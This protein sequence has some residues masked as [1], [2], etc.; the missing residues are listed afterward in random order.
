MYCKKCGKKIPDDANICAYCG[1]SV[2][3]MPKTVL[4]K[5]KKKR[6]CLFWFAIFFAVV[7]GFGVIA[8]I[9]GHNK[10][11]SANNNPPVPQEQRAYKIGETFKSDAFEITI[12]GKDSVK[13]VNDEGG[14]LYSDANGIFVIVHLQYKNIADSAKSLDS[15][16]FKLISNGKEYSPTI[17]MIRMN[18]NIFH[19]TINPGIVKNGEIYFDVPEEIAKSNLT[20]K[21][22]SSFVSDNFSGEVNLF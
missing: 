4:Q 19:S 17:L 16:A 5:T 22:S 14:Y 21:M 7:I 13:R 3:D 11:D 6:G 20:L 8:N 2:H 9:T 12:T 10:G 15:S 18:D 1:I